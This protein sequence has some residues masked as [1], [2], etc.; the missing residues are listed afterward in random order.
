M[1]FSRIYIITYIYLI[2]RINIY[3]KKYTK[4]RAAPLHQDKKAMIFWLNPGF[5]IKMNQD[6][7]GK[8]DDC[9]PFI[10][11]TLKKNEYLVSFLFKKTVK[12][13]F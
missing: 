4:Y 11:K 6:H 13:Y 12:L 3:R 10:N 2:N 8:I 7:L 9:Q 1:F 5:K